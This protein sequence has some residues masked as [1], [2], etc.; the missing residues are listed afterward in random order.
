ML[1]V[2]AIAVTLVGVTVTQR[3]FNN[4]NTLTCEIALTALIVLLH[5]Q[6]SLVTHHKLGLAIAVGVSL[7]SVAGLGAAVILFV[8]EHEPVADVVHRCVDMLLLL[9]SHVARVAILRN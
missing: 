8:W 4:V 3:F 1:P 2:G 6:A 7:V 9:E 5:L